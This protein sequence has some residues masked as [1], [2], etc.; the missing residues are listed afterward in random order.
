MIQIVQLIPNSENAH[1]QPAEI[2]VGRRD[3]CRPGVRDVR[4]PGKCGLV[5]REYKQLHRSY[6][7]KKAMVAQSA[8]PSSL[9][10]LTIGA[11]LEAY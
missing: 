6:S 9:P 1:L 11:G 5:R 4:C 2:F 7:Y 8:A 10:T 3:L